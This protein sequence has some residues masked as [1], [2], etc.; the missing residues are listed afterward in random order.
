VVDCPVCERATSSSGHKLG[1]FELYACSNCQLRF[2]PVAFDVPVN[3]TDVY[4]SP[5]Y[6]ESQVKSI[7]DCADPR[8]FAGMPTYRPFFE[9]A[10]HSDGETLIDLGCGVGRFCHAALANGWNVS[11]IDISEHAISIGNRY[12]QF[13]MRSMSIE[14]LVATGEQY[15]VATAFEVLEHLSDPGNFLHHMRALLRPG[16]QI[17][18]TVPNWNCPEVQ[19]ASQLDWIPPIHLLFFTKSSLAEVAR[20]TG[21]QNVVVG[22]IWCDSFPA[23]WSRRPRWIARRILHGPRS[24]LGLWL[25]ASV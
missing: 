3:Y 15:D 7:S 21:F 23:E 22:E 16:G 11:G 24:P 18:C 17:F 4:E 2:A 19:N 25:H 1:E 12:A 8:V 5:E 20:R 14:Q 9:V 13:P 6:I 10:R